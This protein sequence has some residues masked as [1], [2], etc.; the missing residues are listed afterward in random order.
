M[1]SASGAA[2]RGK[3]VGG[4][5]G[6][7]GE[8]W[9]GRSR[10]PP[11]LAALITQCWE[12]DP[13]RRPAAAE[14]VKELVVIRQLVEK[15]LQRQPRQAPVA[16]GNLS[17]AGGLGG[18]TADTAADA[19]AP[20]HQEPGTTSSL[21]SGGMSL[22]MLLAVAAQPNEAAAWYLC[23]LTES[24]AAQAAGSGGC[25]ARGWRRVAVAAAAA[26]AR[27]QAEPPPPGTAAGA[28]ATPP[29]PPPGLPPA[30]AMAMAAQAGRARTRTPT[31]AR[32]LALRAQRG[33]L[34]DVAVRSLAVLSEAQ[35]RL[36]LHL[37]GA[38]AAAV[39][40]WR[41][42]HRRRRQHGANSTAAAPAA[43]A[44]LTVQAAAA[45]VAAVAAEGD[46][47]ARKKHLLEVRW[48]AREALKPLS[49][50]RPPGEL[51]VRRSATPP[52]PDGPGAARA[53]L[54]RA[55]ARGGGA[56]Q[57]G[58][59]ERLW[60]RP[61]AS[62]GPAEGESAEGCA[63]GGG[64]G[65]EKEKEEA[66][67]LDLFAPVLPGELDSG[68]TTVLHNSAIIL[69]ACLPPSLQLAAIQ[70]I[71]TQSPGGGLNKLIPGTGYTS[72]PA[73]CTNRTDASPM[74]RCWADRGKSTRDAHTCLYI[75]VSTYSY[76]VSLGVAT[77]VTAGFSGY[78]V[79][80][81][82][83]TFLCESSLA[84]D[85]VARLGAIGC[86]ALLTAARRNGTRG[87]A[88]AVGGGWSSDHLA[89]GGSGSGALLLGAVLGAALGGQDV[90]GAAAT[91]PFL[92]E[93][94]RMAAPV[95]TAATPGETQQEQQTHAADD[96]DDEW[97]G[98]ILAAEVSEPVTPFTPHRSDLVMG[99]HVQDMPLQLQ[100]QQAAAQQGGPDAA[101]CTAGS[102]WPHESEQMQQQAGSAAGSGEVV[103][104]REAAVLRTGDPAGAAGVGATATASEGAAA[105]LGGAGGDVCETA[106]SH[107]GGG[108]GASSSP[109]AD[110]V[111]PGFPG[112]GTQPPAAALLAA[113]AIASSSPA[114]AAPNVSAA[115]GAAAGAA[116]QITSV[117]L[118]A[119][120]YGRVV[121]G[122]YRGQ[123]VAVKLIKDVLIPL[124]MHH[125]HYTSSSS[126]GTTVAGGRAD[127]RQARAFAQEVEILA[128]C[129]HPN[130]VQLLAANLTPP[131]VCLV[132]ERMDCSLAHLLRPHGPGT[133]GRLLPLPT[134][135]HIA[136]DI[137]R[138]LAYIHPTVVHRD[139]KPGNVLI[140]NR[141][142]DCP[143]AKLTDFGLSR[144]RST[145][146]AT[147]NPEVGTPTHM[148]P[149]V[150][151]TNNF[152]VTDKVDIYAL[153]VIMWELVTGC[154]PWAG[155]SAME[156]AAAI[157]IKRARLPLHIITGTETPLAT[158]DGRMG[159]AS[160]AAGRGKGVGGSS[161]KPGEEWDGRCRCPP[162]LAALITQC[163]E[164]DPRRRPAAA[165]VVKELVVIR[166]LVEK[167]LQRQPR[168]APVAGGNLSP[169][170]GLRG[171]A[172]D[173]A[174]DARAPQPQQPGTTST[175][176]SGGMSLVML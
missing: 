11:R 90:A 137:A 74:A 34:Y 15:Q 13:R 175:L 165:E 166:Q 20:Q 64:Q 116:V 32:A 147:V 94:K 154:V 41:R 88:T 5:S 47:A 77:T 167:Q 176:R 158:A 43:A 171:P 52:G 76:D 128:R 105:G 156:I 51:G 50:S 125:I 14:V 118:G 18:N 124:G 101:Y 54:L 19:R 149:E 78:G 49:L 85:C 120:A 73:N 16:G 111:A 66:P 150:F 86:F 46:A 2:G 155:S 24:Q 33:A 112:G 71:P 38:A 174:A 152:V 123:R 3:G 140:N 170:G 148:A 136:T 107:A 60:P 65:L 9:D 153:G 57:D 82:N 139:L 168:Q 10:C 92:T 72:N 22:V 145:D 163:W 131:R 146:A 48:A 81:R 35:L 99:V 29:R 103:L 39:L 37:R 87:G 56:G 1:G 127:M 172:A 96:R 143:T 55:G 53:A 106:A 173:T 98:L 100:A 30:M 42:R 31:R 70:G 58:G 23:A 104:A 28:V 44:A 91:N 63:S 141:E 134:L 161:G 59:A 115:A 45:L 97:L 144:L 69:H 26:A 102:A 122:L 36:Q 108:G 61:A 84:E 62:A 75:S 8:E 132:M 138:G 109:K 95:G 21:R 129:R 4:S 126:G 67:G 6:K 142:S 133:L 164:H 151:D 12:H 89:P 169:A 40:R 160:G 68:C 25:A 7:P 114:D 27:A 113:S 80:V 135:L 119:G 130:I 117:V 159:F 93:A 110:P 17:P 83:A 162:R 157:N 121:E 79:W